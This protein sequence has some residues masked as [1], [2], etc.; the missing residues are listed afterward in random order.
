MSEQAITLSVVIPSYNE[1]KNL[2]KG[3]L[4]DVYG[5]LSQQTY[6]WELVL[7]D[8]GSKD[9]TLEQ[10]KKFAE[11]KPEVK[12]LANHHAGKGPTVTSGMLSAIGKYRLFT[13]FDQSTPIS[14]VN[15]A[16]D[17]IQKGY[18]IVIGSREV[19]GAKRNKEP[20]HRHI[21]GRVFNTI[22]QVTALRGIQDS[23]CGFKMFSDVATQ[24]LFLSLVVYGNSKQRKDAFTGAFDVEILFLARKWGMKIKEIPV[25][26]EHVESDR[27]SPIKD[28]LRML[29]DILRIRIAWISGKYSKQ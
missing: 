8:D 19:E 17:A 28:S 9:G 4:D 29:R 21:M 26:W 12:I 10:L 14:E 16:L 24:K 11:N 6:S 7:T 2:Q 18:D 22:V 20:L 1:L 27:V 23:Q 15:I 5:F 3:I 25:L 13:D